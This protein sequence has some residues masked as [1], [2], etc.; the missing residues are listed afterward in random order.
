MHDAKVLIVALDH[1][2]VIDAVDRFADDLR[3]EQ[4]FFGR[5][6]TAAPFPSL[7]NRL[8]SADGL[9]MGAQ[10]DGRL[11]AMAR[12][13]HRGDTSIAVVASARDQGIGRELLTAVLRRAGEIGM[14]RLVLRSS[15]RS[16]SMAALGTSIGATT[17][18]QGCG[19]VDFI[20]STSTATRTA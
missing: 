3:N 17:I 18:D 13:D 12:V 5:R 2:S 4:R 20:L 1:P 14:G 8:T 15:Q 10:V 16:R 9:R 7:I 19:R 6:S 11:V